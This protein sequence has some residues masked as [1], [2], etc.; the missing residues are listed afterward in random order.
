MVYSIPS[1]SVYI[2][3]IQLRTSWLYQEFATI[4]KLLLVSLLFVGFPCTVVPHG[5]FYT[6]YKETHWKAFN[7]EAMKLHGAFLFIEVNY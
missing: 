7:T 5:S 4:V 2:I 1:L 3:L 6:F